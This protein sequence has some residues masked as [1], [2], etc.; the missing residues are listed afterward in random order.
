M[1]GQSNTDSLIRDDLPIPVDQGFSRANALRLLQ[2]EASGRTWTRC[3]DHAPASV[4]ELAK[5][6]LQDVVEVTWM[7]LGERAQRCPV[8]LAAAVSRVDG[9]IAAP[10]PARN[11]LT[12]A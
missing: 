5:W 12:G 11:D 6:P 9:G 8:C 2:W 1:T 10:Q 3:E 7:T 4:L